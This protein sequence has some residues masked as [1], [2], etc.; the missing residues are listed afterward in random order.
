MNA[1]QKLNRTN[2]LGCIGVG[3]IVGAI[4][5]SL[6]LFVAVAAVLIATDLYCGKI[7]PDKGRRQR[8]GRE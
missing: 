5:Q 8:P 2:L 7:R 4:G 6:T 1:R 3:A